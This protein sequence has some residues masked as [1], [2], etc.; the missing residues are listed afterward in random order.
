MPELDADELR[1][2]RRCVTGE[3]EEVFPSHFNTDVETNFRT[4]FRLGE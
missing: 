2:R 4:R 1:L 3:L